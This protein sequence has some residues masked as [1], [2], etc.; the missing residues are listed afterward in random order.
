MF[1]LF[2]A[3]MSRRHFAFVL[4]TWLVFRAALLVVMY[5]A[6]GQFPGTG[7]LLGK[8]FLHSFTSWDGQHY[9]EIVKNGY[10]SPPHS[11]VAFFPSYPL[12]V[13]LLDKLVD[14]D[15]WTGVVLSNVVFVLALLL[16]FA[17]VRATTSSEESARRAVRYALVMPATHFFSCYYT[18]SFFLFAVVGAFY[19]Y[20]TRRPWLYV[21]FGFLAGCTRSPGMW[22]VAATLLG[23]L[24]RFV[25]HPEE[26]KKILLWSPAWLAPLGG[27]GSY[28]FFLNREFGNPFEFQKVM[29]EWGRRF[30]TPWGSIAHE[31]N[32]KLEAYR[33]LEAFGA[34]V[35]VGLAL[36]ALY[37]LPIAYGS[38]YALS[39]WMSLSTHMTA[40]V[41]RY[42]AGT[43][44]AFLIFATFGQRAERTLSPV[45]AMFAAF[46]AASYAAGYFSG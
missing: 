11:N 40:S 28:M 14:D 43:G 6:R 41:L 44:V 38:F 16:I 22:L 46:T 45:L 26:R 23:E 8:S 34:I 4:K 19:A 27:L 42:N 13:R 36:Y 33:Q 30:D 31:L 2:A 29:A 39:T 35:L 18:E 25:R 1:V 12:T 20:Q 32:S 9:H 37:K 21:P 3:A 17:W 10:Q 5:Y 7:R 24:V 15:F